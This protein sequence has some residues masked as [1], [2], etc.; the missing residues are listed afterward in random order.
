MLISDVE[1]LTLDYQIQVCWFKCQE[2]RD[3]AEIQK[4]HTPGLSRVFSQSYHKPCA[5]QAKTLTVIA[6]GKMKKEVIHSHPAL[7]CVLMSPIT[8]QFQILCYVLVTWNL[9]INNKTVQIHSVRK[10]LTAW[11]LA[12]RL[13]TCTSCENK[14]SSNSLLL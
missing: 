12:R 10:V 3:I 2:G 8:Q 1:L 13:S 9:A 6:S 5:V 11:A 4:Y 7:L 14:S